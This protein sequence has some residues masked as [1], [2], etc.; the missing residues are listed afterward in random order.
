MQPVKIVVIGPVGTGKT[1]IANFLADATDIASDYRPTQ[2]VRILEFDTANVNVKNKH[3]KVDVELWDCSGDKKFEDCW[4]AIRQE[5]QGVI[6]VYN[7]NSNDQIKM[8]ERFHDYF[9]VQA[10]LESK[11]CVV[12]FFNS[13]EQSTDVP[14]RISNTFA[15]ISQVNCNVEEGGNKLKTDFQAFLSTLTTRL[16]EKSEQE[17]NNILRDNQTLLK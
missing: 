1:T 6:F 8:L 11:S 9:V 2:G 5:T 16:Q 4:P 10:K 15:K 12:F 14:K 7:Q 3:T 13:N 17:E